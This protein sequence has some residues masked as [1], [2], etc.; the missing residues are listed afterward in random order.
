MSRCALTARQ[1]RSHPGFTWKQQEEAGDGKIRA[2]HDFPPAASFSQQSPEV[3]GGGGVSRHAWWLRLPVMSTRLLSAVAD[4]ANLTRAWEHVRSR[5]A[6]GGIDDVTLPD[7]GSRLRQELTGLRRALLTETYVPDPLREIGVPKGGG[8]QGIRILGLPTVR[9]KV[10]QQAVRS[11]IEPLCESRFRDVSY[12]YRPGR[13][14]ARAV[15]RLIHIITHEANRW[16]ATADVDDCFPSIEI[17][18]LLRQLRGVVHDEGIVRLVELWCR[19]GAVARDGEWRDPERG[20]AQGGVLSPLLANLYLTPFDQS[21]MDR[22]VALVRYAD[23]MVLAGPTRE[24]A[25]EVLDRARRHLAER[26]GLRL[27][28]EAGVHALEEGVDW[29]GI[30]FAGA[31]RAMAPDRLQR[32]EQTLA[33]LASDASR[34]PFPE[35]LAR[36]QLSADGWRRYYGVVLDREAMQPLDSLLLHALADATRRARQAGR[37]RTLAEATA[38][39]VPFRFI[40]DRGDGERRRLSRLLARGE[41]GPR[42]VGPPSPGAVPE[43]VGERRPLSVAASVRR[44]KARLLAERAPET[45]LAIME[46]G[47]FVGKQA[48]EIV[49]RRLRQVVTRVPCDAVK[50]LTLASHGVSLSTDVTAFCARRGIPLLVVTAANDLAAVLSCPEGPDAGLGL[51]QLRAINQVTPALGLARQ[52]V[53][54]K[55]HNQ[56]ALVKYIGKYR[57][58]R[59]EGFAAVADPYLAVVRQLAAELRALTGDSG[60]A[61][62]R[63]RLMGIEGRAAAAYWP[64]FGLAVGGPER[65]THREHR[66]AGDLVNMLLN[67]GYAMLRAR[68]H[69]ALVHAGLQPGLSFLHASQGGVGTLAFDLM[70]EFRPVV[71]RT[72]LAIMTRHR[73][74]GVEGDGTLD[75]ATRRLLAAELGRRLVALVPHRGRYQRL[76][77]VLRQQA[78]AIGASLAG[79]GKYTPYRMRW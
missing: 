14:P 27:N 51:L 47:S 24:R 28:P 5:N 42:P 34:R 68:A 52:F 32:A 13:G 64:V 76:E 60:L 37:L 59:K 29:L 11:V 31:R 3:A 7:F 48:N 49:V 50:T 56:A 30:R 62:T 44:R 70:E 65:F 73:P 71:D 53:A 8:K 1:L 43:Q 58:T 6:A 17:E 45:H 57:R 75:L 69:L 22:R 79:R 78:S 23:D 55:I 66:G 35:V 10:A 63:S 74:V 20:L 12:G 9:D 4:E 21:M 39:L 2:A 77:E 41:S 15:A 18:R 46:P 36:L 25:A 16:V 38:M 72:V 67:Y 19:T 33:G 61:E 26:L 54:G 40:L